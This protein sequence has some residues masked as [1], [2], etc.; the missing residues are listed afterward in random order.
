[1]EIFPNPKTRILVQEKSIHL[2]TNNIQLDW[3]LIEIIIKDIRID[4]NQSHII[5][6]IQFPIQLIIT[7][8]LYWF[9]GFSLHGLTFDPT[10]VKEHGLSLHS[11][12]SHSNKRKIII[13]NFTPTSDITIFTLI[14]A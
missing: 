13:I 12:L 5:T 2:Y 1:L 10:N 7:R 9:E 14:N 4:K 8:T 3:T 11:Y 6:R